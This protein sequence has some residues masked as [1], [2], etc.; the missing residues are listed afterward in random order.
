MTKP[1][2]KPVLFSVFRLQSNYLVISCLKNAI[3]TYV[4]IYINMF[5]LS[6]GNTN[7][8]LFYFQ[9]FPKILI[10]IQLR[11]VSIAKLAP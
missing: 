8:N 5:Y 1:F 3:H 6:L 4:V 7:R 9:R 10:E 11:R 2:N